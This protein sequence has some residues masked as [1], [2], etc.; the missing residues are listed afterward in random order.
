MAAGEEK[1]LVVKLTKAGRV[2]LADGKVKVKAVQKAP[3]AERA[4][5]TFWLKRAWP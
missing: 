5:T 3:G 4:V 2:V 1:R